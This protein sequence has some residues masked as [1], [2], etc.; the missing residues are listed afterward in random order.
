MATDYPDR[1]TL[2]AAC[3]IVIQ[4]YFGACTDWMRGNKPAQVRNHLLQRL[5]VGQSAPAR[6]FF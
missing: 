1:D 2:C 4:R 6:D 5:P 3:R